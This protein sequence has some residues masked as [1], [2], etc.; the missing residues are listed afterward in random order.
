[1]LKGVLT[2]ERGEF[3][4]GL[5][6]SFPV[7]SVPVINDPYPEEVLCCNPTGFPFLGLSTVASCVCPKF[8]VG[9]MG[10][11]RRQSGIY[12]LELPSCISCLFRYKEFQVIVLLK[13]AIHYVNVFTTAFPQKEK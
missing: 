7:Q 8:F 6:H 1:M 2:S 12:E 10:S 3:A 13:L 11:S 5:T 9:D 4:Q